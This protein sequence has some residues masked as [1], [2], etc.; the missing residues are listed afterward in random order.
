MS[1]Q[2]EP[3]AATLQS[4]HTHYT[5]HNPNISLKHIPGWDPD[6]GKPDSSHPKNPKPIR[7][8]PQGSATLSKEQTANALRY[9][10][11][12]NAVEVDH[13]RGTVQWKPP[14]S[15]VAKYFQ[16]RI[17]YDRKAR[18][19][20]KSQEQK[21]KGENVDELKRR[22]EKLESQQAAASAEPESTPKGDEEPPKASP[23]P[24][25]KSKAAAQGESSEG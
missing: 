19:E 12:R 15:R 20:A 9:N 24:K 7:I 3:D 23:K 22:L 16:D 11:I 5:W 14:G 2:K 13:E 18:A 1:K 10:G 21:S 6:I 17:I 4:K 8:P 25:A